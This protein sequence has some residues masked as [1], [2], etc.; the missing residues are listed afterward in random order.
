M[1][2][3]AHKEIIEYANQMAKGLSGMMKHFEATMIRD[4]KKM[5]PEQAQ[6]IAKAFNDSKVVDAQEKANRAMQELNAEL[7]SLK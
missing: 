2:Q 5:N 3:Q 4:A 1:K 7:D 6:I